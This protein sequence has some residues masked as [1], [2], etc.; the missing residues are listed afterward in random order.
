MKWESPELEQ[1]TPNSKGKHPFTGNSYSNRF[2]ESAHNLH[3]VALVVR[4][5]CLFYLLH[6]FSQQSPFAVPPSYMNCQ[7]EPFNTKKIESATIHEVAV[8]CVAVEDQFKQHQR[9]IE[10]TKAQ[11]KPSFIDILRLLHL[12]LSQCAQC[13]HCPIERAGCADLLAHHC[14]EPSVGDVRV[15]NACPEYD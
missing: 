4:S 11:A 12:D 1:D 6:P 8:A 14:Q 3:P 2:A 7:I 13:E 10:Q 5:G 15:S 9:L